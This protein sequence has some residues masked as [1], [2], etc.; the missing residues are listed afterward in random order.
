[1]WAVSN[2]QYFHYLSCWIYQCLHFLIL[3]FPF[4]SCSWPLVD[5]SSFNVPPSPHPRSSNP[6]F[7]CTLLS[8]EDGLVPKVQWSGGGGYLAGDDGI[9]TLPHHLF[10][11]WSVEASSSLLGNT[12]A[13]LAHSCTF[14]WTQLTHEHILL[15]DT[16]CS[17]THASECERVGSQD[18]QFGSMGSQTQTIMDIQIRQSLKTLQNL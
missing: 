16:P 8:L 15:M 18:Q 10:R 12:R 7:R 17:A 9:A 14:L 3:P 4:L 2:I 11:G 1:M 5:L 6:P 13:N